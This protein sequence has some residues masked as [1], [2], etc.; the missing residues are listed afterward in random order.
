MAW[1]QTG[2]SEIR[3]DPPEM[4][5]LTDREPLRYFWEP[6]RRLNIDLT[7]KN[8][9]KYMYRVDA[10]YERRADIHPVRKPKFLPSLPMIFIT[11]AGKSSGPTLGAERGRRDA[12]LSEKGKSS[13]QGISGHRISPV[14]S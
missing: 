3:K 5:N 2:A 7:L 1:R 10:S 13:G 11:M 9:S 12:V 6:L 14:M 8:A 4:N